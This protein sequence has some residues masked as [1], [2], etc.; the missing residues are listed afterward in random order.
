ML[1]FGYTTVGTKFDFWAVACLKFFKSY[2]E[3]ELTPQTFDYL[4]LNYNRK[5]HFHRVQ[6]VNKLEGAGLIRD[7][8]VTMGGNSAYTVN[9]LDQDY[10]QYGA[11]DVVGDIGIPNDI[12]SLGRLD[13]WNCSLINIVSETE[14]SVDSTF[15]SEKV[16][17]PIIGMRPF[18]INGNPKIYSWLT[19]SGFDCF[20]D[21][22]PVQEILECR[23]LTKQQDL[24]IKCLTEYALTDRQNLYDQLLPRLKQNRL[25]F[26]EY[27]K[28]QSNLQYN[29]ID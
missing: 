20:D 4:Y 22:F 19:A 1:R 11:S 5:P 17:K 28:Q 26:F 7:G 14:F 3:E 8:C 29:I 2:T 21:I 15:L 16:Y 13:I 10:L 12:Y 24:I 18:I 9:D 23:N 25:H 6:F 27:A